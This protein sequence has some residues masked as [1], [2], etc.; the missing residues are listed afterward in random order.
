MENFSQTR[1]VTTD[2]HSKDLS[3][4][5]EETKNLSLKLKSCLAVMGH[6]CDRSDPLILFCIFFF[7]PTFKYLG[8]KL[9]YTDDFNVEINL[10][11]ILGA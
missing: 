9:S 1:V 4:F 3:V 10:C 5:N 6:V 11:H 7:I 2:K 8:L